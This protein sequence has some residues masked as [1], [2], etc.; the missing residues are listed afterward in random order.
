M[1]T[2]VFASSKGGVGKSTTAL[3]F[4]QCLVKQGF[5]VSLLDADPNAPLTKWAEISE[6][7]DQMKVIGGLSEENIFETIDACSE[8]SNFV[9]VD[10]EGSAN[11]T[12]SYAIT[13][14]DMVLIPLQGSQ[15]DAA[16][17]AKVI[18]LID[19]TSK[20]TRRK[21]PF[22]AVITRASYIKS[23]TNKYIVQQ[24]RDGGV[25][26][27]DTEVAERDAFKGIFT[28]GGFLHDLTPDEVS[29]PQKAIDNMTLL[30]NEVLSILVAEKEAR[31]NA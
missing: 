9:I 1:P 20:Q 25:P 15:L 6:L 29:S 14:A 12:V 18:R 21:I 30:A 7:P 24:L 23:R 19:R 17:A 28:Y 5:S 8:H 31:S 4:S 27:L 3:A 11:L 26:V 10:L 2:I 22:S 16:E 13:D